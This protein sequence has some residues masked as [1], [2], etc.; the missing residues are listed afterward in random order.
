MYADRVG[1]GR[2][3]DKIPIIARKKYLVQQKITAQAKGATD[4]EKN[5]GMHILDL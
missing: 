2:T 5:I 4:A 3:S 1:V